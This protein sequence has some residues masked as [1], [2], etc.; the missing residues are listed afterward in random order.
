MPETAHEAKTPPRAIIRHW[1]AAPFAACVMAAYALLCL[2]SLALQHF[3][4]SVFVVAGDYWVDA[5][6]TDVTLRVK[7]D[8]DGYDGQFYYR[9]AQH[10]FA[11]ARTAHGI[12]FDHPGKR[13]ERILFPLLAWMVSFGQPA[14]TAWA[15]LGVN[16]CGMGAIAWMA[17][18]LARR[19]GL[20]PALPLAI[21]LWPGFIVALMRDTT[22][23][24]AAAFLL[25]AAFAYLEARLALYA[26]L[27]AC[28]TL[29][30]ETTVLVLLGIFVAELSGLSSGKRRWRRVVVCGLALVPFMMWREAVA[31]LLRESPQADIVARALG[32]PLAGA[33]QMLWECVTGGRLWG[34]TPL[35][36]AALRGI[37]LLTAVPLLRFCGLVA[38][39]VPAALRD[40]RWAGLTLGWVFTAAA[41]SLLTARGPWVDPIAYLRAFTE[42][43]VIG[44]VVLFASGFV[45]RWQWIIL[46]GASECTLTWLLAT[47]QLR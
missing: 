44:G 37:V 1:Q 30:R 28:A 29:A 17:C 46:A 6:G 2:P 9:M 32:W 16:L 14:A 19:Q 21:V 18:A 12:S 27:A 26:V 3:D 7:P 33:V 15:M 31:W 10:P 8:S 40:R 42:C 43:F 22:E 45:P 11:T 39:R 24:T 23:I 25:G 41:M 4:P 35:K 47:V 5:A 38:T 13:M 20:S 36:D 34:S